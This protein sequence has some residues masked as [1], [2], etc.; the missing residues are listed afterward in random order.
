MRGCVDALERDAAETSVGVSVRS[1]RRIHRNTSANVLMVCK[2]CKCLVSEDEG[3]F[4][5]NAQTGALTD[6]QCRCCTRWELAPGRE[7][8]NIPTDLVHHA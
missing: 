4:F 2:L 3:G 6:F 5:V 7:P 1:A 8:G